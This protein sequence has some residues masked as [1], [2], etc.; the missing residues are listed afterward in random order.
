MPDNKAVVRTFYKALG[1]GNAELMR[2]VIGDDIQAVCTGSSFMAGTRSAADILGA[3]GLLSS[4]TKAGIDFKILSMTAEEDRV[5]CETEGQSTLVNG[6]PYNN[7]YFMLFF[8][9]DGKIYRLHEYMDS[10]LVDAALGP[11]VAAA[12]K[13]A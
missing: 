9:R 6:T 1:S 12:A 10:K 8:L 13:Q 5:A 7:Q 2:T 4:L 3:L 11:L